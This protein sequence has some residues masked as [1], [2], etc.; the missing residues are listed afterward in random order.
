MRQG[1]QLK[2]DS[3][4]FAVRDTNY[5]RYG[6][7]KQFDHSYQYI[8]YLDKNLISIFQSDRDSL[9]SDLD[10]ESINSSVTSVRQSFKI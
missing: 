8:F 7:L 5:I 6:I 1:I 4:F 3:Y 2:T 10:F 9:A